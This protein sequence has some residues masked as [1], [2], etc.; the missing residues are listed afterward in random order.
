MHALL[1]ADREMIDRNDRIEP[2]N[3]WTLIE[4]WEISAQGRIVGFGT[5]EGLGR[6]FILVPTPRG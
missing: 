6:G 4:A 5:K 1:Y 2:G 3:G